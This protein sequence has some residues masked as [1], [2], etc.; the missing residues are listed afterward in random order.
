MEPKKKP[1]QPFYLPQVSAPYKFIVSQLEE[2]GVQCA[3]V[4]VAIS[5]L[6]P[7]QKEVDLNKVSSLSEKKEEELNPIF[8]SLKDHILDG[9]HRVASKK[10]KEG[11]NAVVRAIRIEAD[12]KDGCTYLKIIQDRWERQQGKP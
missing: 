1:I 2:F 7:L 5:Q 3:P 10:Y 8:I 11:K 9:H 12:D 4:K 6:K